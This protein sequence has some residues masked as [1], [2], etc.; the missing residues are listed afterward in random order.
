M[1]RIG[2]P[3]SMSIPRMRRIPPSRESNSTTVSPIG[4]GRRGERVANT[5]CGRSSVGGFPTRLN[6]SERSNSQITIR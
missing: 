1:S 2:A 5:P 4:F 3:S 6:P